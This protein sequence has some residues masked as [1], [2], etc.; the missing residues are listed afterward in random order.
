VVRD[1]YD[2]SRH[3]DRGQVWFRELPVPI[4][5]AL[6][7]EVIFHSG[8]PNVCID[9]YEGLQEPQKSLLG[10][11]LHLMADVAALKAHN[12][13]SEQ[14]LGKP[15]PPPS[16]LLAGVASPSCRRATSSIVISRT[17]VLVCVM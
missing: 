5:N 2:V 10:W 11:L 7:T 4:L 15:L 9:A 16:P 8:D 14:N 13:M 12:K 3:N 6:P 1:A 17:R